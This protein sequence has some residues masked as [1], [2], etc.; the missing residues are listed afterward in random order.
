MVD[1]TE[2][3]IMDT[4]HESRLLGDDYEYLPRLATE[5]RCKLLIQCPECP[6]EY[7]ENDGAIKDGAINKCPACGFMWMH[8]A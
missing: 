3:D 6:R 5:C 4:D 2:F 7:I 8:E 1:E